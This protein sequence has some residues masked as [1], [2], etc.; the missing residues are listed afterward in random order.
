MNKDEQILLNKLKDLAHFTYQKNLVS[1]SD[2]LN[3]NEQNIFLTNIN[4]FPKIKYKFLGGYDHA[5]RKLL[6][7]YTDTLYNDSDQA[8]YSCIQMSPLNEKYTDNLTHRDFLGSLLGLGIDRGKVG[9][10]IVE[11]N[12]A[13]VF[14]K[15]NLVTFVIDNLRKVKHTIISCDVVEFPCNYTLKSCEEIK[16]TVQSIR[17]DSVAALALRISRGIITGLIE[18]GKVFINGKQILSNS[19]SLKSGDIVSVRGMGRFILYQ[20]NNTTKKGRISITIQRY[21]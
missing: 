2:Y 20:I 8:P 4:S 19:T 15:F 11:E 9:D 5:E 16:G 14:I 12:R 13:F 17:L 10:I 21:S 6:N 18:G 3:L 1:Y 7:F